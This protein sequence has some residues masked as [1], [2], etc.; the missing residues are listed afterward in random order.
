MELR[1]FEIARIE[2]C[3]VSGYLHIDKLLVKYVMQNSK[4]GLLLSQDQC[5]KTIEKK[6]HMK[7]VVPYALTVGN[8]IYA[9]LCLKLDI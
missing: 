7:V 1:S 8:L 3:I 5:P 9:M 6:D 2:G 4:K